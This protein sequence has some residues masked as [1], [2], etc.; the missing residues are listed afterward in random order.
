MKNTAKKKTVTKA[1]AKKAVAVAAPAAEQLPAVQAPATG[2]NAATGILAFIEQAARNPK[3]NVDKMEK[4]LAMQ[5]TLMEKQAEI[6]YTQAMTR[7]QKVLPR[8][9]KKGRIK[10]TDKNGVE[11]DTPYA[12]YDDIDKVIRPLLLAEGFTLNFDTK[13]TEKDG[14]IIYGTLTHDGGHSK[15]SEM[16]LPLDTSGSKNNLQAMGS[17]ISYGQR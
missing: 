8:I 16:R 14:A 17:T 2:Y 3:V 10:F 1:P 9:S 6:A 7:L 4:L 15:T 11:R 5:M 13:W 12:K